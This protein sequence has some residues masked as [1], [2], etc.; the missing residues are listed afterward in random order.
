MFVSDVIVKLESNH[1]WGSNNHSPRH[2]PVEPAA[3]VVNT[4]PCNRRVR[5][6]HSA[7]QSVSVGESG[8]T[9]AVSIPSR[10]RDESTG[11]LH[12][13]LSEL[14]EDG[15][16]DEGSTL[17]VVDEVHIE[18]QGVAVG[19]VARADQRKAGKSSRGCHVS[20]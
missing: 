15:F 8:A 17:L 6:V 5:I 12:K 18:D 20:C 4:V 2:V 14:V 9:S 7:D 3:H 10:L 11:E 1:G 19:P 16:G 13:L